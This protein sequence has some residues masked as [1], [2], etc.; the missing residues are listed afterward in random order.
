MTD[1]NGIALAE[2]VEILVADDEP[3]DADLCVRALKRKKGRHPHRV[4]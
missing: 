2:P 1:S 4:G 3:A